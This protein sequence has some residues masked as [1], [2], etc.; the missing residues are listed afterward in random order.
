MNTDLLKN[1]LRWMCG[2]ASV[3]VLAVG[4]ACS[5]D[6]PEPE[7]EPDTPE[8]PE[9]PDTPEEPVVTPVGKSRNIELNTQQ[10]A[11]VDAT[12][13]TSF[14]MF[15][16]LNS[17]D[18]AL[19]EESPG[20]VNIEASSNNIV[21][22]PLGVSYAAMALANGASGE[23]RSQILS[24]LGFEG[25]S[26]DEVNGFFRFLSDELSS[27]DPTS[28]FRISNSVWIGSHFKDC[29]K[30]DYISTMESFYDAPTSFVGSFRS[31]AGGALI[32]EWGR[33]VS[34]GFLDR[35][36]LFGGDETL[37]ALANIPYFKSGWVWP[38]DIE[39][40]ADATFYNEDGSESTVKMMLEN[41]AIIYQKLSNEDYLVLR[42]PYGNEAFVMSIFYPRVEIDRC[43]EAMERDK[44][45][46]TWLAKGERALRDPHSVRMPK[47]DV[48]YSSQLIKGIMHGLGATDAFDQD[49]ADLSGM[50][51]L[52][53]MAG[54]YANPY[55]S[56]LVQSCRIAVDEKKTEAASG[57]YVLGHSGSP[58]D[59]PEVV[60]DRPFIFIISERSTGLPLFM[61]RI[62][63]L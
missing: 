56:L 41:G 61:G 36:F 39:K 51:D 17:Q 22:S 35:F 6:I 30:P 45:S 60:F 57:A 48:T 5:E 13:A 4:M 27:L 24:A 2:V 32:N 14:R 42:L 37:M 19:G 15:T 34:N 63:K 23:S 3:A 38:F 49:K 10:Q 62:T 20:A 29:V 53:R 55:G 31:D 1:I 58:T 12:I 18:R 33:E 8:V 47:F 26:I 50:F 54:L 28:E 52:G 59:P 16:L 7:P 9:T 46:L 11:F 44:Q 40:T 25:R 43:I 21:F